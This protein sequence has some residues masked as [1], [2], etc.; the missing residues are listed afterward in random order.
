MNKEHETEKNSQK[1]KNKIIFAGLANG[2]KTSIYEVIFNNKDPQSVQT[3]PTNFFS[4][5]KPSLDFIKKDDLVIIDTGGQN[6]YIEQI[7]R[8]PPTFYQD[9]AS[10]VYVIDI[11]NPE[12]FNESIKNFKEF[13]KRTTENAGAIPIFV[14]FH[15]SDPS[16]DEYEDR[17]RE[18]Y[19]NKLAE[20]I[21]KIAF[22]L[23]KNCILRFYQTSIFDKESL[24][25]VI[26]D[27]LSYGLLEQVF[28]NLIGGI[29]LEESHNT[30]LS[31]FNILKLED[32]E[33]DVSLKTYAL[34][35]G[36]NISSMFK[37]EIAK[38]QLTSNKVS[39]DSEEIQTENFDLNDTQPRIQELPTKDIEIEFSCPMIDD[40]QK[41]FPL[42]FD[43]RCC[44]ITHGL[45][46]GIMLTLD[47]QE[48]EMLQ[49]M[50]I[51]EAPICKFRALTTK[52]D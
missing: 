35:L 6:R 30:I 34:N 22:T 2:G 4:T 51:H 37:E 50:A 21:E 16:S 31:D 49:T 23:C 52:L 33:N 45:L 42:N 17:K 40:K 32:P 3:S 47:Y 14:F 15:K 43:K 46:E 48:V 1:Q 24:I 26:V 29:F 8:Q 5:Y 7:L 39:D 38:L 11:L 28:R 36:V 10:L 19:I 25:N 44:E 20:K 9:I 13:V 12:K 41:G 27:V 18:G